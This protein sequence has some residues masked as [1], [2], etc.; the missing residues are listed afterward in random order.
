GTSGEAA[1][2]NPQTD[3]ET[4]TEPVH[5]TASPLDHGSPSPRPTPTT[6]AAQL[7]EPVLKPPRPIPTSPSAQVNQQ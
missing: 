1:P 4:V 5:K 7:N 2:P 3:H 6:P